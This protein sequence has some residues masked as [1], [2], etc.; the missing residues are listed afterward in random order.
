MIDE[1]PALRKLEILSRAGFVT[2]LG[3]PID[4]QQ[5]P[6]GHTQGPVNLGVDLLGPCITP[7]GARTFRDNLEAEIPLENVAMPFISGM[8]GF[9]L[10]RGF[11]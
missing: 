1:F 6:L 10:S 3:P 11:H 9:C 2:I 7:D 5:D 8:P 4:W